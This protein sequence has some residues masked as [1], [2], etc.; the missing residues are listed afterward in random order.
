MMRSVTMVMVVFNQSNEQWTNDELAGMRE[1]AGRKRVTAEL[2]KNSSSDVDVSM[3]RCFVDKKR[4]GRNLPRR[5]QHQIICYVC[6]DVSC[7]GM[8]NRKVG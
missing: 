5:C 4:V 8:C 6:R 7:M 1:R 3:C 2:T